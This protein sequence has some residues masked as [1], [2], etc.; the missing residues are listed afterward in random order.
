M[1]TP[2]VHCLGTHLVE[3]L[4]KHQRTG[5]L[6]ESPIERAHH[7]NNVYS[8]LFVNI[9]IWFDRQAAIEMRSHMTDVPDVKKAGYGIEGKSR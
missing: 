1:A 6:D 4:R 7:T 3:D 9:K 2:N 8:R 5:L